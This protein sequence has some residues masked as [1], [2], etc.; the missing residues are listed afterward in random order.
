MNESGIACLLPMDSL[1][2][3]FS[4]FSSWKCC[5]GSSYVYC[6]FRNW[7]K[8][9]FFWSY[10]L[11]I[12]TDVSFMIFPETHQLY[13]S[14]EKFPVFISEQI[15]GLRLL[16]IPISWQF[17]EFPLLIINFQPLMNNNLW[18]SGCNVCTKDPENFDEDNTDHISILIL[19]ILYQRRLTKSS[20]WE[21][22]RWGL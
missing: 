19:P 14:L 3:S 21:E 1:F 2:I 6:R 7:Y 17:H 11:D 22:R 5:L 8:S 15:V 16:T 20:M 13:S 12:L 4:I 10:Y 9:L 18:R